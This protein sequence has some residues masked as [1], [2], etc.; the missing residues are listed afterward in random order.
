M[1]IV[2]ISCKSFFLD[3]IIYVIK[4]KLLRL[5]IAVKSLGKIVKKRPQEINYLVLYGRKVL[6]RNH[7]PFHHHNLRNMIV[8]S[9][10][11]ST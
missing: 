8:K 6:N 2:W 10:N 9:A 7:A 1:L 4:N 5:I 3:D 11:L